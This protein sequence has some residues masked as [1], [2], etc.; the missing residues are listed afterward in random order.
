MNFEVH[1]R[2]LSKGTAITEEIDMVFEENK[3]DDFGYCTVFEVYIPNPVSRLPLHIGRISIAD[4][5]TARVAY[6]DSL[7]NENR[8]SY[9][10]IDYI[11]ESFTVLP[12]TTVSL[13]TEEYYTNL[14]KHINEK[15][16]KFTMEEI[17]LV[18][19]DIAYNKK[20]FTENKNEHV[21][22][23]SFLRGLSNEY[24]LGKLH[25]IARGGKQEVAY[26]FNLEYYAMNNKVNNYC[27]ST[28]PEDTLPTNIHA[29][30]GNN[31]TGKTRL[32]K[33]IIRA[34]LN[35]GKRTDSNFSTEDEIELTFSVDGSEN[36]F[37]GIMFVSFSP[38]DQNHEFSTNI[39]STEFV[40]KHIG[41]HTSSEI[42]KIEN[43]NNN[44]LLNYNEWNE[45]FKKSLTLIRK[46][47][48]KQKLFWGQLKEL[49]FVI[50][51]LSPEGLSPK[52][53][54]IHEMTTEKFVKMILKYFK[55]EEQKK[56]FYEK[57]T[58]NFKIM[59]SGEKIV[60]LGIA[61]LV[62]YVEEKTLVLFDE[63]ELYLHPPLLANY[64][65]I[66][67]NI[68]GEKNG[69]AILVTHS[70]I[71]LQEI[72]TSCIYIAK[73]NKIPNLT[74]PEQTTFGENI[75]ILTQE[76]FGLDIEKSGFYRFIENYFKNNK[77]GN[78][79]DI[80]DLYESAKLGSEAKFFLGLLIDSEWE[81]Y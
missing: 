62:A 20:L 48:S 60:L 38:F 59:S 74:R 7:S 26:S 47:R 54:E 27:F 53:D 45:M 29:I 24:V 71:V 70:P 3:W 56:Q 32:L 67:S 78:K 11:E 6:E 65:R 36:S 5:E 44:E 9:N 35:N 21:I 68:V 58:D 49:D 57:L 52:F 39:P 31:G 76:V 2:Y 8:L 17:M 37:S 64:I 40:F 72:P 55:V 12:K 22:Q 46:T 16:V 34:S 42:E 79:K 14:I 30:I 50:E 18:L 66:I 4:I 13:G 10:M 19:N 41:I 81:D 23:T 1:S 73:K 75:S 61:A 25:R 80:I 63:P 43:E 28:D 33:D 77:N 69:L 15:N 51:G